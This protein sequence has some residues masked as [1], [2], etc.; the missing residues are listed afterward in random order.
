MTAT[1]PDPDDD[2]IT[3]ADD[4]PQ[5]S[6]AEERDTWRQQDGYGERVLDP[7]QGEEAAEDQADAAERIAEP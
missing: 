5:R 1:R 4:G 3:G 6:Q 2:Q 7:D